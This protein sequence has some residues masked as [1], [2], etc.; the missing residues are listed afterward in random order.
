M[1]QGPPL[2][3]LVVGVE[4]PVSAHTHQL[5]SV[6]GFE[7]LER[8]DMTQVQAH[9]HIQS[10]VVDFGVYEVVMWIEVLGG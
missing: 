4:D 9:Q 8:R 1:Y 5:E 7:G 10:D 6:L 3:P 2:P